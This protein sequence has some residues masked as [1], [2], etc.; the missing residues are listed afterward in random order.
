MTFT[1]V[2]VLYASLSTI[3]VTKILTTD[4]HF[5]WYNMAWQAFFFCNI[6]FCFSYY[7]QSYPHATI[8]PDGVPEET[9]EVK[10]AKARHFAAHAEEQAKHAKWAGQ[11]GSGYGGGY[12]W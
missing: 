3:V 2:Q 11:I 8:T 4:V 5:I 10:I 9:P 7:G 12:G 6:I 1:Q